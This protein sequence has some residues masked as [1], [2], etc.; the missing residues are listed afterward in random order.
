MEKDVLERERGEEEVA[1][2][3]VL[4]RVMLETVDEETVTER[5]GEAGLPIF[6]TPHSLPNETLLTANPPRDT[7]VQDTPT[8]KSDA[9]MLCTVCGSKTKPSTA[10]LP[11]VA[12]STE[13]GIEAAAVAGMQ[14]TRVRE[15]D[16]PVEWMKAGAGVVF[17]KEEG[18]AKEM[19]SR[20]RGTVAAMNPFCVFAT[21]S[22]I[23]TV[24]VA[25]TPLMEQEPTVKEN[26]SL[27]VDPLATI[28]D[29]LT[30]PVPD[31]HLSRTAW[32]T[33]RQP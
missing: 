31:S 21:L 15:V 14:A 3:G 20:E 19:F 22:T 5:E 7:S 2:R 12:I 9:D 27:H 13:K 24:C 18:R 4:A 25:S 26:D 33:L 32:S 1:K 28:S 29:V 6:T 10:T 16:G 8:S 30:V 23:V 17:A 11:A